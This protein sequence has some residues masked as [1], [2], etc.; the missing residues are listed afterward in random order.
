MAT[1]ALPYECLI[2]AR[3]LFAE[4]YRFHLDLTN[5]VVTR[6]TLVKDSIFQYL[7]QFV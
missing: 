4:V 2:S 6:L 5:L 7:T 3:F 1:F